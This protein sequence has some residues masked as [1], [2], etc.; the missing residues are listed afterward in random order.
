M[1]GRWTIQSALFWQVFISRFFF[2]YFMVV[3][4]LAQKVP[5]G[6]DRVLLAESM[7]GRSNLIAALA[8]KL[9]V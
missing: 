9:R 7:L 8:R 5:I 2:L 3:L 6:S 4:R 1:R